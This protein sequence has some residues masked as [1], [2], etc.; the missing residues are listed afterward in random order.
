MLLVV[1]V[2]V[3]V[4]VLVVGAHEH[5]ELYFAVAVPQALVARVGKPVVAVC[6]VFVYVAQN[7]TSDES[8]AGL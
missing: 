6:F 1:V 3:V 7:A 8:A 4:V 2:V 5:A